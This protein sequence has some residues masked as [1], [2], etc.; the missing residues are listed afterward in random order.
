MSPAGSWIPMTETW[1]MAGLDLTDSGTLH[2]EELAQREYIERREEK[3][4]R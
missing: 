1:E 4:G 2:I 3:G